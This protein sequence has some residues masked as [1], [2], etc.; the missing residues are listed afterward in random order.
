MSQVVDASGNTLIKVTESALPTGAATAANQVTTN[1]YLDG[2]EGLLTTIDADTGGILTA[3]Q[4]LDN[5]IAGNEMQVDVVAPLPAGTNNIGDVDVLTVPADPFGA[6]ADAASATGSISAKLRFIANTGIPIT[7]TAAVSMATQTPVG[8]VA[9]DA[10]DSGA[11]LK[12]GAIAKS[13]DQT[14][15]AT[16]D[17]T[18]L[19]ATLLGK[20]VGYPYAL[21]GATWNYAAAAGGLVSTTGVTAKAA[22]GAGIRNYVTRAQIINSHQTVS[23]EVVIRDGA[24]GTVLWRGWAQA[25]GGGVSVVFDPPLRG[26]ADTLIEIAEVSATATAGVLVNL[27]GFVAGE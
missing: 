1:G 17:R 8:N 23:T 20:L 7:G 22:A 10:A 13:T 24:A 2:V 9:H 15:V 19:I 27:Q 21:P 25:A 16:D 5:A 6:N 14:A 26:T 11:P 4:T 18:N 12:I 3:V